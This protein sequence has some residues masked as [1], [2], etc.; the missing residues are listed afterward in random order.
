[1]KVILYGHDGLGL[2]RVF[3]TLLTQEGEYRNLSFYHLCSS[4]SP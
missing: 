4:K 1:M 3:F 2:A